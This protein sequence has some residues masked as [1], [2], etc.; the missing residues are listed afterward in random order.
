LHLK[1]KENITPKLYE[2]WPTGSEI[3]PKEKE[4]KSHAT[5]DPSK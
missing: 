3:A 4:R 5:M 2:P 1:A